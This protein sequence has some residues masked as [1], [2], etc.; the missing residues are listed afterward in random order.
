MNTKLEKRRN[1]YLSCTQ[2]DA[3]KAS[4]N[5]ALSCSC[6]T[7]VFELRRGSTHINVH[8]MIVQ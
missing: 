5:G 2:K 1:N 3:K 4:S 8:V 6:K 7:F